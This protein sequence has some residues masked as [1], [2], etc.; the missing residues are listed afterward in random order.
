M[1]SYLEDHKIYCFLTIV[2]T[3]SFKI[4]KKKSL[5]STLDKYSSP[6]FLFKIILVNKI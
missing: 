1:N 6:I 2:K 3:H 5:H 4:L